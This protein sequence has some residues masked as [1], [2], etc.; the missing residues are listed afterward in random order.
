MATK[1]K[2][3]S[4]KR[5]GARYGRTVKHNLAKIEEE[6]R[7]ST[8]CPFC[9]YHGVKRVASGIFHCSKCDSKFTGKSYWVAPIRSVQEMKAAVEVAVVEEPEEEEQED[10]DLELEA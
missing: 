7:K 8:K 1:G 2:L 5:F 3:G 6:Q 10:E 9:N 4:T